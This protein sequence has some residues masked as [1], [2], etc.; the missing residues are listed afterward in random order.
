MVK[1]CQ[2]AN[3]SL[4]QEHSVCCTKLHKAYVLINTI[5][6]SLISL[7]ANFETQNFSFI[8]I[9]YH[10]ICESLRSYGMLCGVVCNWLPTFRNKQFL[11]N[12]RAVQTE[13]WKLVVG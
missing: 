6:D 1:V 11:C 13:C 9:S 5:H 4:L 2:V 7:N 8:A 3:N 10:I 12:D